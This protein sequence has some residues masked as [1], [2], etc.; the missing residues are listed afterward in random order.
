MSDESDLEASGSAR[1]YCFTIH[2][3]EGWLFDDSNFHEAQYLILQLEECPD[4]GRL[5]YQGYVQCKTKSRPTRVKSILKANHAHLEIRRGTPE[6]A[7]DYCK[8]EESRVDGPWEYG[9]F[10]PSRGRGTRTD[11]R[12]FVD[13][14]R[15]P[16]T[17]EEM[18]MDQMGPMVLRFTR[19]R[20]LWRH[21]HPPSFQMEEIVLRPWQ[22]G[23]METLN[24]P[25]QRRK[26]YWIW[27]QASGTGKTTFSNYVF[28][29]LKCLLT[30]DFNWSNLVYAVPTGLKVLWFN[31]PYDA[32]VNETVLTTLEKASD[33]GPV[34]S[35][36]YESVQKV[37]CAH[38]VVTS[39]FEP[40][41]ERLR[42]RIVATC[43][44]E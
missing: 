16:E 35:T 26:I 18:V 4:S 43:L 21:Y 23:L 36:K 10:K 14:L 17:T 28:L 11:V 9:E 41:F 31:L 2:L 15:R 29:R 44:D 5:H 19:W 33:G 22:V 1:E 24:G 8:K 13:F 6:Q 12:D 27:S 34:F 38:V 42:N 3:R 7:R 40:P 30:Q 20:E 32:V 37:L 25:W 39:N